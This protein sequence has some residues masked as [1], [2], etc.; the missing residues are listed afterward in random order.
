MQS[1][2]PPPPPMAP[3]S[4]STNSSSHSAAEQLSKTNLY[5]RGLPPGTTDQDLIKLCQPVS[6]YYGSG[7]GI[8]VLSGLPFA[9]QV[10]VEW[11]G[12]FL[13]KLIFLPIES[14]ALLNLCGVKSHL[15]SSALH[16]LKPTL[17]VIVQCESD[18]DSLPDALTVSSS[19]FG[20]KASYVILTNDPRELYLCQAS[21]YGKIVST[22]AILDKNTNQCKGYGFVDF[23]SPAAAQKAVAS[24]KASGVQAQMAK[25][26]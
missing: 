5:I 12:V 17:M 11:S 22:K 7:G 18:Q 2:A 13:K 8:C 6:G 3:P 25:V 24:L 23:D 4:P 26:S 16:Q 9:G 14:P 1:Y 15:N 10:R 21:G 20:C 19:T